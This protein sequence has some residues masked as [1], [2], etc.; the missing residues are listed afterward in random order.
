VKHRN[1]IHN[2]RI[3]RLLE[4]SSATRKVVYKKAIGNDHKN[5]PEMKC[6]RDVQGPVRVFLLNS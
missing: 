4:G 5:N 3:G 1:Y 6:L 2:A